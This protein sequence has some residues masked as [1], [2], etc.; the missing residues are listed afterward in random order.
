MLGLCTSNGCWSMAK[1]RKKKIKHLCLALKPRECFTSNED[2]G[3]D[4]EEGKEQLASHYEDKDLYKTPL[5]DENTQE[6]IA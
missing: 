1:M 4:N 3:K 5:M 6:L 2:E